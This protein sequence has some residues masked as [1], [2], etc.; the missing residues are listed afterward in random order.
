M[1]VSVHAAEHPKGAFGPKA[2]KG[3]HR[4]GRPQ[5]SRTL[6]DRQ[7]AIP[8]ESPLSGACGGIQFPGLEG[9]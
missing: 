6:L 3:K 9:A 1:F 4:I 7:P 8:D 5:P 2:A